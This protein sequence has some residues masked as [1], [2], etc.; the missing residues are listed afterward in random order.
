VRACELDAVAS[1]D[2]VVVSRRV[3]ARE[4]L[5]R[6]GE[7]VPRSGEQ[8]QP[9]LWPSQVSAYYETFVVR[10]SCQWL[11]SSDSRSFTACPHLPDGLVNH[12]RS[13]DSRNGLGAM[14]HRFVLHP[15]AL[16][17]C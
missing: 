8:M 17:V 16:T 4:P 10:D 9:F 6:S 1:F 2:R 12:R 13:G 11:K 3:R 7:L 14:L 15:S 5:A